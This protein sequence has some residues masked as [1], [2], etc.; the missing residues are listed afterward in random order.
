[1]LLAELGPQTPDVDVDRPRA[2]VVLVAPDPAEQR[3]AGEDLARVRGQEAEQLVL[4]VGQVEDP[5]GDGGLVGLEVELQRPVLDER[6]CASP[7][8]SARGG[9]R[10]RAAISSASHRAARRS[11]RRGPRGAAGR[12]AGRLER[13]A[14]AGRAGPHAARSVPAQGE[15][16]GEGRRP[17][18]RPPPGHPAA[19]ALLLGST[20]TGAETH[21]GVAGPLEGERERLGQRLREAEE[22]FHRPDGPRRLGPVGS[23]GYAPPGTVTAAGGSGRARTG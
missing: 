22:G 23:A 5:P 21:R 2:A 17:P 13:R 4:H 1:M 10:R 11:R 16:P 6:R 18:R 20:S 15:G 9:A 19:P 7:A 14:A 12:R 3:L 8:R